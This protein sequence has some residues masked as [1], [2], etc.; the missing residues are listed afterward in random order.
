MCA[1]GPLIKRKWPDLPPALAE[2]SPVELPTDVRLYLALSRGLTARVACPIAGFHVLGPNVRR[3]ASGL[4]VGIN[5]VAS[6]YFPPVA[7]EL[8]HTGDTILTDQCWA[9][10]GSWTNFRPGDR[11][12][13][14]E[15][16]PSL[17]AVCHPWHHPTRNEHWAEL[18]SSEITDIIECANVDG[19]PPDPMSPATLA[20]RAHLTTEE[21][22][23]L[24]RQR[25]I[26]D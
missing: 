26:L 11:H 3:A 18:L 7:W 20:K 15:L 17:P 14:D 25:G 6:V 23:E 12:L 1:T 4:L 2:G 19:G 9:D 21:M 13:L 24:A 22:Q 10:V 5:A 8:V 16:V